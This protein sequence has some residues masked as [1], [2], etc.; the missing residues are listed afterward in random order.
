MKNYYFIFTLVLL[1]ITTAGWCNEKAI[2]AVSATAVDGITQYYSSMSKL[3]NMS[4]DAENGIN[5]KDLC[6]YLQKNREPIIKHLCETKTYYHLNQAEQAINH[7]YRNQTA[8][9]AYNKSEHRA[10]APGYFDSITGH[11]Y[12]KTSAEYY[13]EYSRTGSFLKAV[14]SDMPLL[15]KSRNI[16]LINDD[17]YI[18]YQ[19]SIM[20]GKEYMTLPGYE[21]HPDGWKAEK[22]LVI[23]K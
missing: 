3:E 10:T 21:K 2:Y 4:F 16:H 15:T 17:D 19:K 12:Y 14:P 6:D 22:I 13:S 11:R 18:L 9:R 5:Y 20:G 23:L 1:T 7:L 8:F